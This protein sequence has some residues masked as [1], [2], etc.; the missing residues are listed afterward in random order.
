MDKAPVLKT[1]EAERCLESSSL[2]P[3]AKIFYRHNG[4]VGEWLNQHSAKVPSLKNGVRVRV[5]SSPLK[6]K[7]EGEGMRDE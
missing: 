7:D 6:S 3:S 2:S 1:G 4:D 5:A